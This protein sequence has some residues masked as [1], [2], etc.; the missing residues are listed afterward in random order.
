VRIAVLGTPAFAV[1]TL[2]ALA[3]AGHDVA[4]VV[5]QPDRP[6][7]RGQELR[8]PPMAEAARPR[9]LPLAQPRALRSGP[10]P[11]RFRALNLDVAVVVAY[12]RVL[13]QALL[14]APR[15]GC[16]NLHASLLP[17]WRGAAPIQRAIEAGDGIT[18]VCAQQM[19]LALDEGPLLGCR[20]VPIGADDTG[21]SLHDRLSEV[22]A[23]VAVEVLADLPHRRAEPQQG[24]PTWAPPLAKAD[25][26]LDLAGD[27]S[28]LERR[29]RAFFPWPGAFVPLGAG[30][31][32]VVRARVAGGAGA[33]GVVTSV[34]PLVVQC[35][36]GALRLD[37]V[38]PSGRRAMSGA[39]FARGAR[40]GVGTVLG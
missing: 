17:R 34:D 1:P 22:A 6:A 30:P 8:A 10:F 26:L 13:P 15:L 38:V 21:G 4:L 20:T 9:G 25:G 39:E 36:V 12:G 35:G 18:G 3:N 40:I 27:A 32:R 24:M 2:V 23:E 5:A 11:D 37:E 14:D 28:V 7:G 19:V 16:V 31:L 29:V 33:P